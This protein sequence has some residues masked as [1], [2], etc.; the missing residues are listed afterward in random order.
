MEEGVR[1]SCHQQWDSFNTV[2][3]WWRVTVNVRLE[4]PKINI[5]GLRVD[6]WYY[7]VKEQTKSRIA[8][9][10]SL[11]TFTTTLDRGSTLGTKW[12]LRR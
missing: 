9:P 11:S 6:P 7:T 5:T 12:V 3:S 1:V 2:G 4:S 10:C 8:L